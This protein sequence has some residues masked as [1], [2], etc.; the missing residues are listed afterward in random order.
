[1]GVIVSF[2]V[3]VHMRTVHVPEDQCSHNEYKGW[4]STGEE[5][6]GFSLEEKPED[7]SCGPSWKAAVPWMV[8]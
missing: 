8:Q 3:C 5:R 4:G 6:D 7:Y 1:M 2:C